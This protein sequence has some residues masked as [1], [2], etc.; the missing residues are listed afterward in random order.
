VALS[1]HHLP[2]S[3]WPRG[4]R[5]G[6]GLLERRPPRN[7]PDHILRRLGYGS[8]NGLCL[9]ASHWDGLRGTVRPRTGRGVL[10]TVKRTRGRSRLDPAY[11]LVPGRWPRT[12]AS[13]WPMVA[14]P[15][16]TQ[17]SSGRVGSGQIG[18][19]FWVFGGDQG[20]GVGW[21]WG[22]EWGNFGRRVGPMPGLGAPSRRQPRVAGNG[23]AR[24]AFAG[25]VSPASLPIRGSP[26][27]SRLPRAPDPGGSPTS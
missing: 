4:C 18:W 25:Q 22:A 2:E 20:G 26:T 17:E 6:Q 7:P 11:R 15:D 13:A 21:P 3:T 24:P 8:G 12:C 23:E 5:P 10:S 14:T 1:L 27:T 9:A 16:S 19:P